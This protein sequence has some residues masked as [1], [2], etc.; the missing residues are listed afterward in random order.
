MNPPMESPALGER[1]SDGALRATWKRRPLAMR[2][3]EA[4]GKLTFGAF[5]GM[6]AVLSIIAVGW[7]Q[8]AAH[9]EVVRTWWKKR[10][11]RQ[12][13]ETF[14]QFAQSSGR[15]AELAGWPGWF[16]GDPGPG[17]Q[18]DW[19]RL[20]ERVVGGLLSNV[21]LGVQS[22]FNIAV[23]T[24]PG[25]LLWTFG[26]YTGWMNSFHKGYENYF[27]GIAVFT[28]GIV[29]YIAAMLYVPMAMARQA[30]TAN[31][32]SFYDFKLVWTLIQRRWIGQLALAI[33]ALGLAFPLSVLRTV[34]QFLPQ[35]NPHLADLTATEQLRWIETYFLL[36][37]LYGFPAFVLF[38]LASARL[39]AGALV[40]AVQRGVV[41]QEQLADREWETL[42]DLGLIHLRPIPSRHL[43]IRAV[44]WLGTR[45][46]R[47]VAWVLTF[48]V[49]F[50]FVFNVMTTE[51]LSYHAAGRGWWNHPLTQ[52]P[53]F[54]YTP[55][56]LRDEAALESRGERR[57]P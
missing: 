49:W 46:G 16:S 56:R 50:L 21:R 22:A 31:W 17:I 11:H 7:A 12:R 32:K 55:Q 1:Q 52:L 43:L 18:G 30:S 15:T 35:M 41:V 24:L 8:R 27:V 28:V 54:D 51:F 39:Y 2:V 44:R 33:L 40:D 29:L 13:G 45:A 19:T 26:W 9:R 48:I 4:V 23:F 42:H 25:G 34:P 38:R 3:L 5:C 47:V 6:S 10:P 36:S 53:W 37:G 57:D 14:A 20:W